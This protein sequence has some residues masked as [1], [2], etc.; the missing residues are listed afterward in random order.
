MTTAIKYYLVQ[1]V[2]AW[3]YNSLIC[4]C[5]IFHSPSLHATPHQQKSLSP[6]APSWGSSSNLVYIYTNYKQLPS[7]HLL[8]AC[9]H[10]MHYSLLLFRGLIAWFWI[11]LPLTTSPWYCCLPLTT[12]SACGCLVLPLQLSWESSPAY[13]SPSELPSLWHIPSV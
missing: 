11:C 8:L 4:C 6:V 12:S 3:R 10:N 13:L 9:G 7:I 5:V 2:A 1:A